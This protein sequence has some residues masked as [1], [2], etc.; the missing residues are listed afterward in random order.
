M[1]RK[2]SSN[3]LRK[4]A[5]VR[6]PY[7]CFVSHNIAKRRRSLFVSAFDGQSMIDKRRTITH[8]TQYCEWFIHKIEL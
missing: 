7:H 3:F 2:T 4:L 6:M 8:K 1:V 5:K